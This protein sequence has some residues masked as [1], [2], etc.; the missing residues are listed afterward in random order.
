MRII[1]IYSIFFIVA[2]SMLWGCFPSARAETTDPQTDKTQMSGGDIYASENNPLWIESLR[3][4]PHPGSDLKI[5]KTLLQ[6]KTVTSILISYKVGNL[7]LYALMSV[8]RQKMPAAGFPVIM[9]N[10]GH[11]TPSRYS[12]LN[13]YKYVADYYA[14]NGFL[15]LKPDY[16]GHG[17]SQAGSEQYGLERMSYPLDVLGLLSLVPRIKEADPNN[18]FMVGHSMGGQITLTVLEVVNDIRAAV[19]WAP[20]SAPFPESSLYFVGKHNR[21]LADQLDGIYK[22]LYGQKNF[23]KFSPINYT[24]YITAALLVQHGTADESVPYAWTLHMLKV[25]DQNHIPYT[26]H[27]FPNENH[28]LNKHSFY[29]ALKQD[30]DFFR[31]HMAR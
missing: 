2:V 6:T 10:H 4:V 7:K 22:S 3:A 13:S 11:I 1:T 5:E 21:K 14:Q 15:V 30:V 16:R 12:T 9:L 17:N 18:I 25:F 8:P 28:N 31:Q 19:L 20:V 26:F 27:S 29:V 24:Q 23:A